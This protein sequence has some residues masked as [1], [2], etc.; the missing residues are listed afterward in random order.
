MKE[1]P[2]PKRNAPVENYICFRCGRR[3]SHIARNCLALADIN[4][5]YVSDNKFRY[6]DCTDT[7]PDTCFR[8]GRNTHLTRHCLALTHI[9][10]VVI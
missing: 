3:N 6:V 10:G 7:D 2:D 5:S 1:K 4:G 9:N 8:C